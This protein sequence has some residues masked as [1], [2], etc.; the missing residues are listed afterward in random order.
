MKEMIK[1]ILIST[2]KE[3]ERRSQKLKAHG[4]VSNRLRVLKTLTAWQKMK[5]PTTFTKKINTMMI[6]KQIMAFEFNA[7]LSREME[8]FAIW[9]W[10]L[11][12]N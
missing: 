7:L 5:W 8:Q 11:K 6:K 12:M 9:I 4:F 10:C 2:I 1:M 3:K